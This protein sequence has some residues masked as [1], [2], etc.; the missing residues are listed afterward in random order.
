MSLD[1]S[2]S[3]GV[4]LGTALALLLLH[5][6]DGVRRRQTIARLGDMEMIARMSTA[7]PHV[8]AFKAFLFAIATV[9]C[10]VALASQVSPNHGDSAPRALDV[11]LVQSNSDTLLDP[12][13]LRLQN[14]ERLVRGLQKTD[15]VGTV[16][17]A[18]DVAHFPL[19]LDHAAAQMLYQKRRSS[20]LAPGADLAEALRV[21]TWLL[22]ED[23]DRTR[24]IVLFGEQ[25]SA[26][27]LPEAEGIALLVAG[28]G[29][30][31]RKEVTR[32]LQSLR[33]GDRKLRISRKPR[34]KWFLFPAFLA[35][36]FEGRLRVRRRG[37]SLPLCGWKGRSLG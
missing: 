35:L 23:A 16:A 25:G 14:S 37:R 1:S 5:W 19:T 4:I 17:Y 22:R 28:N 32:A 6:L 11:I 8:R 36:T 30:W 18:G 2:V 3:V 24:V 13:H 7:R 31:K 29:A 10:L 12:I 21:A 33:R 34:F 15:R 26:P 9:L 27:T 20:Q